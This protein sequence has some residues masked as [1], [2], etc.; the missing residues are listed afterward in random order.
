MSDCRC[1]MT[2]EELQVAAARLTREQYDHLV[3]TKPAGID[4]YYWI[5]ANLLGRPVVTV[6]ERTAV[7]NGCFVLAYSK[8]GPLPPLQTLASDT[9]K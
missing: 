8:D 6:T 1:T 9:K 4:H 3:K 5:A 7:K 2:P